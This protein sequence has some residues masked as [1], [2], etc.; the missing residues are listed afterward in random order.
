MVLFNCV[1]NGLANLYVHNNLDI[2]AHIANTVEDT[3]SSGNKTRRRS[4]VRQLVFDIIFFLEC[5]VMLWTGIHSF[6]LLPRGD[7]NRAF[8]LRIAAGLL[9][10]Y[11]VSFLVK[12]LY[13]LLCHPWATLISRNRDN[14]EEQ[15]V[16]LSRNVSIKKSFFVKSDRELLDK[17]VIFARSISQD[18]SSQA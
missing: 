13:Y 6:P 9:G 8:R 10:V 3:S 17:T 4:L 18:Q 14:V 7:D 1:L 12:A 15:M 11:L 5:T 16:L 2:F